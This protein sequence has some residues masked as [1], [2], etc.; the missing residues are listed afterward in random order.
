MPLLQLILLQFSAYLYTTSAKIYQYLLISGKKKERE[1]FF[2]KPRVVLK[3]EWTYFY[4]PVLR[5]WF[6]LGRH[7][8][9]RPHAPIFAPGTTA[10]IQVVKI[11][12]KLDALTVGQG[13]HARGST[14]D[15]VFDLRGLIMELAGAVN[16]AIDPLN[17][18]V[19]DF[20]FFVLHQDRWRQLQTQRQLV[21]GE[22]DFR[23]SS[24]TGIG[25]QLCPRDP[26]SF[27]NSE[28]RFTQADEISYGN[29]CHFFLHVAV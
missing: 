18:F 21:G 6:F 13:H 5:L 25:E 8:L 23:I 17:Y 19:I 2:A 11:Y 29:F 7:L 10:S 9:N 16:P 24:P 26:E 22:G 15:P 20:L 1:G 27:R 4:G 12:H 28:A 3:V 14:V